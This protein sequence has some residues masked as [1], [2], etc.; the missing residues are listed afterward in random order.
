[1]Q[2]NS[3]SQSWPVRTF[4]EMENPCPPPVSGQEEPYPDVSQGPRKKKFAPAP[5]M[6]AGWRMC[7]SP[8]RVRF[9]APLNHPGAWEELHMRSSHPAHSPVCARELP[10]PRRTSRSWDARAQSCPSPPLL[11]GWWGACVR[12]GRLWAERAAAGSAAQRARGR[13]RFYLT[14]DVWPEF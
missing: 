7:R 2:K 5:A 8:C 13:W 1:M 3:A 11:L 10:A 6:T 12:G 14:L 4:E 9:A